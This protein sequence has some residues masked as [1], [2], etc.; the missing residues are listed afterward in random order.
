MLCNLFT[1]LIILW[2][3]GDTMSTVPE[4]IKDLLANPEWHHIDIYFATHLESYISIDKYIDY[5]NGFILAQDGDKTIYINP[6][7][8]VTITPRQ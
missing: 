4:L 6:D 8:I 1:F 5:K 7:K 3:G 2:L